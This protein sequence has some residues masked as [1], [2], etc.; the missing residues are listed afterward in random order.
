MNVSM[1]ITLPLNYLELPW[2]QEQNT[3]PS[4]KTWIVYFF[5]GM[6]AQ[7]TELKQYSF[8]LPIGNRWIF[9]NLKR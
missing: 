9:F 1:C 4:C 6:K 7:A 2:K 8:Y 5:Q 3:Y